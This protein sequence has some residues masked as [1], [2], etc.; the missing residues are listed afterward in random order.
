M[1]VYAILLV[2]LCFWGIKLFRFQEDYIG[3]D[4]TNCIKGI[5]AS[6]ILLSHLRQYIPAVLPLDNIVIYALNLL[7]QLMVAVFFFYSGYGIIQAYMKKEGYG[8]TFFKTRVMKILFHFD[9]AVLCYVLLS[10]LFQE[11]Y[12]IEDYLLCWIGWTSVGNSNWF[13][14]VML[15]LYVATGVAFFVAKRKQPIPK[16]FVPLCTSIFSVVLWCTLYAIGK[17]GWWY[18]TLLCYP[19]GM[20][21]G[22]LQD[23]FRKIVASTATRIWILVAAFAMFV[24]LYRISNTLAYSLCA[25]LFCV[26]ILLFN[27]WFKVG[28][29]ALRWLGDHAFPIYIFQ[30]LPMNLFEKMGLDRKPM[31]FLLSSVAATVALA[32]FFGKIYDM[33]D[34]EIFA[35]PNKKHIYPKKGIKKG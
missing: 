32:A 12:T 29:P 23:Q 28:N 20:W 19:F 15:C 14:F 2:V 16:L 21:F 34:G 5:F 1:I 17:E 4:Q 3:I 8:N 31:L 18:N 13:V 10:L 27:T 24:Y 7:G 6:V 11:E 22:V 35:K 25:C 33:L 26:L 9:I 30:R